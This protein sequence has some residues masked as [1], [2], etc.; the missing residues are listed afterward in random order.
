MG[1][2]QSSPIQTLS[3]TL[4]E[5]G[6][7]RIIQDSS[8]TIVNTTQNIG[9]NIVNNNVVKKVSSTVVNTVTA[10]VQKYVVSHVANAYSY[11]H[12]KDIYTYYPDWM[13][14]LTTLFP[15]SNLKLSQMV[16][17]GTHDSASTNSGLNWTPLRPWALTQI[18]EIEQQLELGAR[19]LD[20]RFGDKN[21]KLS[22]VHGPVVIGGI[23]PEGWLNDQM[24]KI[25]SW[26]NNHRNEIIIM[27][28]KISTAG[29]YLDDSSLKKLANIIYENFSGLL[30]D[31]TN[32]DKDIRY[33]QNINQRVYC[34]WDSMTTKTKV[35]NK[36]NVLYNKDQLG[37]LDPNIQ[38]YFQPRLFTSWAGENVMTES[39]LKTWLE[40]NFDQEKKV[41]KD[42]QLK[43]KNNEPVARWSMNIALPAAGNIDG[44]IPSD[45]VKIS[46]MIKAKIPLL[47]NFIDTYFQ[48]YLRY[49][50][51]IGVD[52]IG[53][54]KIVE[55]CIKTNIEKL[56]DCNNVD[57]YFKHI[58]AYKHV[59]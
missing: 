47:S 9:N 12:T 29:K 44:N 19:V 25:R 14:N 50:N 49:C 32:R 21:G 58:T 38:K 57:T 42:W 3:K 27:K 59:M 39:Q 52:Y 17:P 20:L 55:Y 54:T 53:K 10:P 2:K 22:F 11:D 4:S 24:K 7:S 45:I 13:G 35:I 51:M 23:T 16:I 18:N 46:S 33:L 1:N 30:I 48:K 36:I 37:L 28:C 41:F 26:L 6:N 8:R 40:Q 15:S 43:N 56:C 5:V 31:E 34:T